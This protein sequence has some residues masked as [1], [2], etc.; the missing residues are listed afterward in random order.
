MWN[1][2]HWAYYLVLA[3]IFVGAV[4]ALVTLAVTVW[5]ILRI[6]LMGAVVLGLVAYGLMY[7]MSSKKKPP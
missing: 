6:L 7:A 4:M 3:S 5:A 2:I 1:A